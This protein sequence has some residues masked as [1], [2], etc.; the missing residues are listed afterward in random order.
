MANESLGHEDKLPYALSC[1][2]Q[3]PISLQVLKAQ[4][5]QLTGQLQAALKVS[6]VLE[7]DDFSSKGPEP[8]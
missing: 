1:L 5:A 6:E 3:Q 4:N 8:Y 2:I 7:D